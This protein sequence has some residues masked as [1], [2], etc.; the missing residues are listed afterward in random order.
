MARQGLGPTRIDE[1]HTV[2]HGML[3]EWQTYIEHGAVSSDMLDQGGLGW[4]SRSKGQKE[5]QGGF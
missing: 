3:M 4:I 2:S 5:F 1:T